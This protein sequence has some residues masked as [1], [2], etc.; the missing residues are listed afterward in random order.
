MMIW[1]AIAALPVLAPD[2]SNVANATSQRKFRL[3]HLH[4]KAEQDSFRRINASYSHGRVYVFRELV[5]L[6]AW[7]FMD[8]EKKLGTEEEKPAQTVTSKRVFD[9]SRRG[10]SLGKTE[11]E[12]RRVTNS[13]C[14]QNAQRRLAEYDR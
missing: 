2:R 11:T 13:S 10:S 1:V 7:D 5:R 3:D 14:P 12:T 8:T 9:P 6:P 4:R